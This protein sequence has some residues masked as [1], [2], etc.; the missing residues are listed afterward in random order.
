MD[1]EMI[2]RLCMIL[3]IVAVVAAITAFSAMASRNAYRRDMD[4]WRSHCAEVETEL[5]V[6]TNKHWM[7]IRR[8]ENAEKKLADAIHALAPESEADHG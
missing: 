4:W 3:V 2:I 6:M 5:S 1:N 8:A 7:A